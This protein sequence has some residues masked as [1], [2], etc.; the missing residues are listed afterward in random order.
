M[1]FIIGQRSKLEG[2]DTITVVVDQTK[3]VHFFP[4]SHPFNEITVVTTFTETVHRLH[5]NPKIIVS[6]MNPIFTSNFWAV[7]ISCLD[8]QFAYCFAYHPQFDGK[9]KIVN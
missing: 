3:Y 8:T 6:D 7:L 2:M 5:G 9:T 1:Y 4:L